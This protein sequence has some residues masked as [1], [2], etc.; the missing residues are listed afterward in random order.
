MGHSLT[1]LREVSADY[2]KSLLAFFA[3]LN[4]Q[5]FAWFADNSLNQARNL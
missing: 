1:V 2:L 3:E 5:S 4:V